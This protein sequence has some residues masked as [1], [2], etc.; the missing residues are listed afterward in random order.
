MSQC[1]FWRQNSFVVSRCASEDCILSSS[2]FCRS[3][4][5][6]TERERSVFAKV[7]DCLGPLVSQ[8]LLLWRAASASETPLTDSRSKKTSSGS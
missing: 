4:A 7:V 1:D 8:R 5:A 6:A 2:A 3:S